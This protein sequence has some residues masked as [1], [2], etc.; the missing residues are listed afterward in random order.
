[1]IRLI[2]LL[3]ILYDIIVFQASLSIYNYN[4]KISMSR[5]NVEYLLQKC[6]TIQLCLEKTLHISESLK[7]T[8]RKM[9][10]DNF[11]NIILSKI[12]S[13]A[14]YVTGTRLEN[15]SGGYISRDR[16]SRQALL[17]H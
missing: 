15:Y 11:R 5:Y 2:I 9:A 4:F 16:Y 3:N 10:N 14:Y 17:S 13:H 12:V 6:N 1:M 8:F 7:L